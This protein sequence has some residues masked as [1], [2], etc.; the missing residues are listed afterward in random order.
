MTQGRVDPDV[1]ERILRE[2][3][4]SSGGR[5]RL[6]DTLALPLRQRMDYSSVGR[7][8]FLAEDMPEPCA[9]CRRTN[10]D[11]GHAAGCRECSVRSV[12]TA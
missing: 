11:E 6:A 10:Y 7:K 4:S 5:R 3:L 8:T 2:Y 9:S 12:L 1:A